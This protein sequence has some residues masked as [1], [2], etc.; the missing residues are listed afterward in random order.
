[1]STKESHNDCTGDSSAYCF[2][3]RKDKSRYRK[4]GVRQYQESTQQTARKGMKKNEICEKL[5]GGN[6]ADSE[7]TEQTQALETQACSLIG[8]REGK[9]KFK[10]LNRLAI[11]TLCD[12]SAWN[13]GSK[14]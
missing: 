14:R 8:K 12:G 7:I 5:L 6:Q 3:S 4:L 10:R 1:M 11:Y 9:T 13:T 2:S